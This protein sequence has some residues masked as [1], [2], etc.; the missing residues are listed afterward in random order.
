MTDEPLIR[1]RLL[2]QLLARR[3]LSLVSRGYS[4][5]GRVKRSYRS[6]S[7]YRP[8]MA[9]VQRTL[10]ISQAPMPRTEGG[11]R[12]ARMVW[13]GRPAPIEPTVEQ[14]SSLAS[15]AVAGPRTAPAV[16]RR[17]VAGPAPS[18]P[19]PPSA[20]GERPRVA[21]QP[22]AQAVS[23]P[24]QEPPAAP[25][26][27]SGGGLVRGSDLWRRLFPERPG[28]METIRGPDV[29]RK[30]AP[31]RAPPVIP[32]RLP[33]T[34]TWEVKPG[35][36]VPPVHPS[37]QREE[38]VSLDAEESAERPEPESDVGAPARAGPDPDSGEAATV[39][40][41]QREPSEERP[42]RQTR[43]PRRPRPPAVVETP[44]RAETAGLQRDRETPVVES[45]RERPT[46]PEPAVAEPDEA[47]SAAGVPSVSRRAEEAGLAPAEPPPAEPSPAA[48]AVQAK[49]AA[50]ETRQ[51]P[52]V[53]AAAP[54]EADAKPER[55]PAV[56][57]AAQPPEVQRVKAEPA[58]GK[59]RGTEA[60]QPAAVELPSA[61]FPT[62]VERAEPVSSV[63]PAV[64]RET[65]GPAPTPA[66][67]PPVMPEA[68]A[69]QP[70]AQQP[71]VQTV[72]AQPSGVGTPTVEVEKPLSVQPTAPVQLTTARSIEAP[73]VTPSVVPPEVQTQKVSEGARPAAV[74]RTE[75]E[76]ATRPPTRAEEARP[77]EVQLAAAPETVVGREPEPE[78]PARSAPPVRPRARRD[79]A[80]KPAVRPT[81]SRKAEA[82]P[83]AEAAPVP[84][85]TRAEAPALPSVSPQ[86]EEPVTEKP[87]AAERPS[88]QPSVPRVRLAESPPMV[89]R[90]EEERESPRVRAEPKL[91]RPPRAEL[92]GSALRV[93]A[94]PELETTAAVA[95]E[96][97]PMR[98]QAEPTPAVARQVERPD[99][100]GAEPVATPLWHPSFAGFSPLPVRQAMGRPAVDRQVEM[101]VARESLPEEGRAA[102]PAAQMAS[103]PATLP[104]HVPVIPSAA[105]QRAEGETTRTLTETSTRAEPAEGEAEGQPEVDKELLAREVYEI[106]K[107]RMIVEREQ[108]WGF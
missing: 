57:P 13:F 71:D 83:A 3:P 94:A 86:A 29:S 28:L 44:A 60:T 26:P 20:R 90:T 21:A 16:A 106:L 89:A 14:I 84:A 65:A 33:R 23:G 19:R 11:W 82:E 46:G 76:P 104:L 100:G 79:K 101:P 68:A 15:P 47:P 48:A 51:R 75:A 108:F 55:E 2:S 7:S 95:P 52:R 37:A 43:A 91:D 64:Q 45:H 36:A 4:L 88:V 53:R 24:D 31:R 67:K 97:G 99:D 27:E 40:H 103:A 107:Q 56:G 22:A 30:A 6:L 66:E 10:A 5:A 32:S 61:T 34:R 96:V 73:T 80:A 25:A 38:T 69:V 12:P 50:P 92:K 59:P 18:P 81:V 98:I 72:A 70:S 62:E 42:A 54:P 58:A 39:P 102:R 63:Q 87:V 85:E 74:A 1:P 9:L 41:I 35:Q 78:L 77:S 105:V 8:R 93:Q 49:A 17:P